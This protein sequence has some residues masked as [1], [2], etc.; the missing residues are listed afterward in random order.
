MD[1]ARNIFGG[2][3]WLYLFTDTVMNILGSKVTVHDILRSLYLFTDTAVHILGSESK[4]RD[5][6][7]GYTYSL[8]PLCIFGARTLLL[9]TFLGVEDLKA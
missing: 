5:I 8:I 2:I 9:T 1:F 7:G 3:S 4:I 6:L